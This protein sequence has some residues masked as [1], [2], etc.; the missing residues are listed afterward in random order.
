[1][2]QHLAGNFHQPGWFALRLAG[3]LLIG[4]VLGAVLAAA[5]HFSFANA[6]CLGRKRLDFFSRKV[7]GLHGDLT[8]MMVKILGNYPKVAFLRVMKSYSL[9]IV[10]CW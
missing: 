4:L 9:P 1:M 2:G 3:M 5:S 10:F 7:Q 8:V 6:M